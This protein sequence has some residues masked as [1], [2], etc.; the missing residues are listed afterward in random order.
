MATNLT[1]LNPER[2]RERE[3]ERETKHEGIFFDVLL[4]IVFDVI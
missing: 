4:F 3:R 1:T 2:E